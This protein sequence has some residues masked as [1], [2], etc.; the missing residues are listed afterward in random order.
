MPNLPS[1]H[2]A[3]GSSGPEDPDLTDFLQNCRAKV[4]TQLHGTRLPRP[5]PANGARPLTVSFLGWEGS[6]TKI[7]YSKKGTKIIS[8]GGPS[9]V[10]G[11]IK[12]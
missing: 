5:P 2:K 9:T 1:F 11:S 6:P 3:C 8:S 4:E 10:F 12:I 7:D